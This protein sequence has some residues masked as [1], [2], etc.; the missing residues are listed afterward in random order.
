MNLA[1][2]LK[3]GGYLTS[4]VS[5]VLLAATS[6]KSA[7]EHPLLLACLIAGAAT[8]IGGMFLRWRS[9][10]TEQHDKHELER[11]L[12]RLETGSGT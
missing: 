5:V 2:R 9:H 6:W 1:S 11:R 3:R 10:R 12:T 4:G 8:S 7:S